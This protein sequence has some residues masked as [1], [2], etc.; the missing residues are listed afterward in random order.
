MQT[1]STAKRISRF[2]ASGLLYLTVG[3]LVALIAFGGWKLER[4]LNW[5]FDYG[6]RVEQRLQEMEKRLERLERGKLGITL[7]LTDA[8]PKTMNLP[9]PSRQTECAQPAFSAA[10]WLDD[11]QEFDGPQC[12]MCGDDGWI[13]LSDAG[14]GEWGEDCFCDEDRPIRCPECNRGKSSNDKLTDAGTKDHE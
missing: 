10:G 11:D 3:S 8:G 14:P 1:N 2:A 7:R 9:E 5:K 6:S 4:W 13:M 12:G